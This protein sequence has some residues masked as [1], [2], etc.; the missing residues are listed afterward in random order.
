[1][2]ELNNYF[3]AQKRIFLNFTAVYCYFSALNNEVEVKK[4]EGKGNGIL[5]EEEDY[6]ASLNLENR[7]LT[8]NVKIPSLGDKVYSEKLGWLSS[9]FVDGIINYLYKSN[10][11]SKKIYDN[12]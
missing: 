10:L 4:I 5:V 3:E 11:K 6:S 2:G 1:M 8:F 12:K 7:V 9:M